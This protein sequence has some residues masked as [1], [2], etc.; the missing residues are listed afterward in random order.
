MDTSTRM[1]IAFSATIRRTST[2]FISEANSISYL[3]SH[4]GLAAINIWET[5]NAAFT[6]L[7]RDALLD[8]IKIKRDNELKYMLL[9]APF[10]SALLAFGTSSWQ[11]GNTLGILGAFIIVIL[12]VEVLMKKR[13][14]WR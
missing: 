11:N 8:D 1:D 13:A 3:I 10:I 5:R 12:F 14:R 4:A 9:M 7:K 2:S 6:Y